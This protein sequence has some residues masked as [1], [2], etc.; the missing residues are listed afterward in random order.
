MAGKF[1]SFCT[2]ALILVFCSVVVFGR[3]SSFRAGRDHQGVVDRLSLRMIK[4][5]GPS[6]SGGGHKSRH[7]RILVR[8]EDSGPSP[9]EGHKIYTRIHQ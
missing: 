8:A 1:G 3:H 7:A 5:S 2:V 9:G 6:Q 4:H